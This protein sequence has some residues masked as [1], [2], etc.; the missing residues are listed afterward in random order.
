MRI[1]LNFAKKL[2]E[3]GIKQ[4]SIF[5]YSADKQEILNNDMRKNT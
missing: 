1:S 5:F 4:E 2:K 3:I